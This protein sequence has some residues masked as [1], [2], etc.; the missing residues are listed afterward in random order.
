MNIDPNKLF[1][2]LSH[3][4]R[5]RCIMLLLN[6]EELCVCEFTHAIGVA[7]PH[8]SRN[9]AQLRKL[10]L[11]TDRREGLWIHYRLNPALPVWV[12]SM[13]KELLKGQRHQSPFV[14]D[15]KVLAKLPNRPGSPRCA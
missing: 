3:D 10:G 1:A 12:R 14:D 5:L 7:Q 13:L 15:R 11:V 8:I 4:T 9:L 2:A 6:H